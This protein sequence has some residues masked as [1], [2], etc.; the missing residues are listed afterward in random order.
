MQS[1][2]RR[3]RRRLQWLQFSFSL[4]GRVL[5]VGRPGIVERSNLGYE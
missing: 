4:Y 2:T 3:D 1:N 5:P